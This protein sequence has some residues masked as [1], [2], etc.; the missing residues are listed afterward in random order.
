MKKTKQKI[1]I[2][3]I[4]LIIISFLAPFIN[5][6]KAFTASSEYIYSIHDPEYHLQYWNNDRKVWSY[7]ITSYVGYTGKDGKFYPAYCLQ[8]DKN[9]VGEEEPYT[10]TVTEAVQNPKVWRALCNGFPY[11]TAQ[12]LEVENDYDAF[13]AT[14]QAIY[15]VIYDY[16]PVTRYRG[17][18]ER[19]T[20]IAKAIVKIVNIARTSTD[21]Y[22]SPQVE[23]KED[24]NLKKEGEYYTQTYSVN[25]NVPLK[26]YKV[27]QKTKLP[28]GS[29]FADIKGHKKTQFSSNETFKIYIPQK[30]IKSNVTSYIR[31]EGNCKTYPVLYGKA[32]NESLQDYALIVN[33]FE[34]G[35]AEKKLQIEP[36][37]EV[38]IEKTSKENNIW[39]GIASG[40][41]IPNANYNLFNSNKN[42]IG[43][44]KTNNSGKIHIS[45]LPLGTYYIQETTPVP[46]YMELNEKMY[47]FTLN[48]IDEKEIVK[49][50]N[51]PI[52]G[53]YFS[54][55]KKSNDNNIWTGGKKNQFLA[56]AKYGIYHLNGKIVKSYETGKELVSISDKNGVIFNKEKLQLGDYYLQEIEAPEHYEIDNTKYYFKV[57]ENEQKIFLEQNDTPE[58]GN[59]ITIKK[60]ASDKN[61][62]TGTQK[63]E[64]IEGAKYEV[65]T[66]FFEDTKVTAEN[67]SEG[68]LVDI[69]ITDKNGNTKTIIVGKG[70]Y[71]IKEISAPDGWQL[72]EKIYKIEVINNGIMHKLELEDKPI[73]IPPITPIPKLPQTGK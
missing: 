52:L 27:V 69:L 60:V 48:F 9:G 51:T 63:G 54:A 16:D 41:L 11:K 35:S 64:A 20:K 38:I 61:E 12:E 24:G 62:I 7:L 53:G 73:E 68:K 8:A 19:G 23:I 70:T 45:G 39:N 5:E 31:V 13:C 29:Y 42:L 10:V 33:P 30:S 57:T 43:T 25:S 34:N 47:S 71:Y 36:T 59:K 15:S 1:S 65:R 58:R 26:D 50:T 6:V 28:E 2:I 14:K 3:L 32:P 56:G 66:G 4:F 37:G 21:N 67:F 40:S 46:Q 72:D 17:G 18:D 44:Y 49:V 22:K 55:I